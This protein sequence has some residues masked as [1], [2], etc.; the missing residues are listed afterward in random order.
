M[1][2]SL[3]EIFIHVH[4]VICRLS[5]TRAMASLE[6][7]CR[8]CGQEKVFYPGH[9]PAVKGSVSRQ[10][11]KVLGQYDVLEHYN[12]GLLF[13]FEYFNLCYLCPCRL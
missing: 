1:L 3:C 13:N 6:G 12:N 11:E 10:I 4:V 9:N 7:I 5:V 2:I 8:L